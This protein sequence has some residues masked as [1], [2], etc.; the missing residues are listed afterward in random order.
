MKVCFIYGGD[1]SRAAGGTDR[2][3]AFVRTLLEE[4][5]DVSAII[6]KPASGLPE[7]FDEVDVRQIR[8]GDYGILDQPIRAA[9]LALKT[10]RVATEEDTVIQVEHATLGGVIAAAGVSD[11]VLDMHDLSYSSPYYTSLPLGSLIS[12][13]IYLIERRAVRSASD[14]IVVSE[15]MKEDITSKWDVSPGEVT[16][17]PNGHFADAVAEFKQIDTVPGRVVF[18][19]T[20]HPKL[21]IDAFVEIANLS[22]TKELIIIGEGKA[23]ESIREVKRTENLENIQLKGY[24]P[25]AEAFE[26]VAS[27]AVAINPQRASELQAASSPVKLTYY[28]ALGTAMVVTGG[29]SYADE[30]EEAGGAVVVQPGGDFAGAVDDLL[31]DGA[32][33][34]SMAMNARKR[35]AADTWSARAERLVELYQKKG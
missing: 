5:I 26:L 34:E 17:I 10:R 3:V 11:F 29:P 33:R 30:L 1:L 16:V 6:A 7:V 35:T 2:I 8:I 19:G 18:L 12:R 20:L 24:L 13:L 9:L 25:D 22:E 27:A 32:R 28:G 23:T 4:G 14:I 31:R 21:D 15:K